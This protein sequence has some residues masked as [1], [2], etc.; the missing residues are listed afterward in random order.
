MVPGYGRSGSPQPAWDPFGAAMSIEKRAVVDAAMEALRAKAASLRAL[1]E[2][3]FAG[4]IHEESR[5]EN[6]K[7]TRALEA[8]YLARGQAGRVAAV[9]VAI[10]QLRFLELRDFDADTPI[11]LSALVTVT[12]E[13]TQRMLMLA[14]VEGGLEVVASGQKVQLLNPASP[15]GRALVGKLEGDEVEVNAGGR[16][17][18]YEVDRVR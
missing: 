6:D 13:E 17:R 12:V 8:S 4:A 16:K 15:L 14:P 7:D 1:A 3:T 5:P 11:A 10:Q 2:A 9:E 18:L